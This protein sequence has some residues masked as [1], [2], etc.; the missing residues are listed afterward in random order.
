MPDIPAHLAGIIGVAMS[1]AI[2]W[3]VTENR[4]LK[5]RC[6]EMTDRHIDFLTTVNSKR[7][8]K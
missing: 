4:E 8:G 2:L 7:R 3:L 5:K 1:S 6:Q